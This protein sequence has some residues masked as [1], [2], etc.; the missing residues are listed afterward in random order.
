MSLAVSYEDMRGDGSKL[1]APNC[2][3]EAFHMVHRSGEDT[4]SKISK[5]EHASATTG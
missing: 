3:Q 2:L 5:W 1:S 4:K